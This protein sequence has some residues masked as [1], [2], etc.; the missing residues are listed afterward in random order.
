MTRSIQGT[1]WLTVL[2]LVLCCISA[3]CTISQPWTHTTNPYN[4][5]AQSTLEHLI[6][7]GAIIFQTDQDG[8]VII[9]SDGMKYS[10]TTAKGGLSGTSP[11]P[12]KPSTAPV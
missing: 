1:A 2:I 8:T 4:H 5:P 7:T 3:G 9:Q 12:A 11:T 10:V 6:N